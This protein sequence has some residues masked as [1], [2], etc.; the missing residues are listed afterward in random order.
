MEISYLNLGCGADLIGFGLCLR[1]TNDLVR[2]KDTA[3]RS[4]NLLNKHGCWFC[5]ITKSCKRV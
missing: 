3:Y 1:N 4:G 2:F 5:Q